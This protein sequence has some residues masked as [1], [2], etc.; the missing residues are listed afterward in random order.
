MIRRLWLLLTFALLWPLWP[1]DWPYRPAEAGNIIAAPGMFDPTLDYVFTGNNTFNGHMTHGSTGDT[2]WA[3]AP[4]NALFITRFTTPESNLA[5]KAIT[6]GVFD[7]TIR[8]LDD[9]TDPPTVSV[10]GHAITVHIKVGTTTA[11]SDIHGV[12]EA[13]VASGPASAL[14]DAIHVNTGGAMDGSGLVPAM[15]AQALLLPA[16]IMDGD[17]SSNGIRPL[18][19]I[20]GRS[21]TTPILTLSDPYPHSPNSSGAEREYLSFYKR[22]DNL[23]EIAHSRLL[24]IHGI[25]HVDGSNGINSTFFVGGWPE[26]VGTV[27]SDDVD[28]MIVYSA[29]V[30]VPAHQ[31]ILRGLYGGDGCG[32]VVLGTNTAS[33]NR[34]LGIAV[35]SNAT[36]CTF[37]ES[38]ETTVLLIAGD[39]TGD[40]A[41]VGHAWFGP[42][43][44]PIPYVYRIN[45]PN[46]EYLGA[47][48]AAGGGTEKVL[49]GLN[50]TDHLVTGLWEWPLADIAGCLQSD[51][52]GH[53]ALGSCSTGTISGS[54]TG[55]TVALWT[56]GSALGNAHIT[57]V[58]N[59]VTVTAS[60][61]FTV[62][63]SLTTIGG[64]SNTGR[65][66]VESTT[67]GGNLDALKVVSHDA[68]YVAE[69]FSGTSQIFNVANAAAI[70]GGAFVYTPRNMMVDSTTGGSNLTPLIVK[71]HDSPTN[72]VEFYNGT[73]LESAVSATGVPTF[74]GLKSTTGVR[75]LCID[76]SGVVT[77]Q[78]AACVGT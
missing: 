18:L 35:S 66:L 44:F 15:S 40:A 48:V 61:G 6:P 11:H 73:T 20:N 43:Q 3:G 5:F 39:P 1:G 47:Q 19:M 55:G 65:L 25:K 52:S 4:T 76:T 21:N 31:L 58:S 77:S 29:Q 54:G 26:V 32:T 36:N 45:I 64:G 56:S 68:G 13:V 2:L 12:H 9:N 10:V 41:H 63:D 72:L 33:T 23:F 14:V 74:L 42:Y 51:G 49:I 67:G 75:Y 69:F 46:N 71:T 38:N 34:G 70:N 27:Q 53:L 24:Y 28:T 60:G 7:I 8:Y 30:A 59:V 78:S 17:N 50:A 37:D 16:V 22:N 62:T 57:D